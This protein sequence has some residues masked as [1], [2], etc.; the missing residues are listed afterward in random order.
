MSDEDKRLRR[1][2]CITVT[3]PKDLFN[4]VFFIEEDQN[5]KE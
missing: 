5:E 1:S 3:M 2:P 4:H